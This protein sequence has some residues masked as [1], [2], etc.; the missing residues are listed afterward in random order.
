MESNKTN[1]YVNVDRFFHSRQGWFNASVS[2]AAL[3]LA[4]LDWL[5]HLIN[6]P[7][8]QGELME[9]FLHQTMRGE[10]YA[11]QAT[12]DSDCPP[13]EEPSQQDR[14]FQGEEWQQWPYNVVYQS[15]L[16]TQRWWQRATTHVEGVSSHHQDVVSFTA[17]QLL[18][19]FSPSNFIFTNPNVWKHTLQQGGAN[20]V[21]GWQNFLEDWQ[22][23][24]S[25][26]QPVGTENFKVGEKLGITPAK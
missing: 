25:G 14:R 9:E 1:N 24:I 4:F 23:A 10:V 8:K 17:H 11:A 2:S 13:C 7:G 3:M 19:I 5:V 15:F 18:D 16:L 26:E 12:M 21:R 22:R 20:L 6:S